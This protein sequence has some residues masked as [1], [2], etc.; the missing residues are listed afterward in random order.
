MF[1]HW[2]VPF[3][4][5]SVY[6]VGGFEV[7]GGALLALGVLTRLLAVGF[8]ID[9]IGAFLFAGLT[10]GA[11]SAIVLQLTLCALSVMFV[12]L[13]GGVWQLGPDTRWPIRHRRA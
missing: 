7:I 6:A 13:G 4:G 10:M 11:P 3:A 8:T 1:H 2:H 9:M 5:L 12:L